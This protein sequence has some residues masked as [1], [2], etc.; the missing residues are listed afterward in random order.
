MV[1]KFL[2]DVWSNAQLREVRRKRAA[3]IVKCPIRNTA[4][5]VE[6]ILGL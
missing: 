3:K 6:S 2:G 4:Q 5:F 1:E